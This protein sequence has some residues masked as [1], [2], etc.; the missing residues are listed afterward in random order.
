MT[1]PVFTIIVPVYQEAHIFQMF[2]ESL[3]VS[4]KYQTQIIFIND[5]SGMEVGDFLQEIVAKPPVLCAVKVI[6]HTQSKGC[7]KCI[8]E[9][10]PYILGTYTVFLDSDTILPKNWQ[11]LTLQTASLPGIDCIGAVLLYPQTGG[12]QSCGIAYTQSLGRHLFLNSKPDRLDKYGIYEVQATVF[13]FFVVPTLILNKVGIIN[14]QYFNGY[15]D[16]D[17]QM[18]IRQNGYHIKINPQIKVYHWE[19]SNGM[20]RTQNRKSNLGLFWSQHGKDVVYDLWDYLFREIQDA[21][22]IENSYIGIDLSGSRLD[23]D[24]FW[25][26]LH[27][28]NNRMIA[29]YIDCS[30]WIHESEQISIAKVT[31]ID[32]FR[33]RRPLLFLCDNFIQ[34]LG[35]HYWYLLRSQYYKDDMVVD[36]YG[37]VISFQDLFTQSWPGQKVR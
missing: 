4:I 31:D 1:N 36:L 22:N 6:V 3:R 13:A 32:L 25:Q 33:E 7:A 9:A 12:I 21:V 24:T 15:E 35:N 29:D 19:Q 8:N 11:E 27:E 18:R 2:Y 34:L 28:N 26:K 37:N 10:V 17:Y 23:A 14:E 20:H 30:H 16:L 5:N